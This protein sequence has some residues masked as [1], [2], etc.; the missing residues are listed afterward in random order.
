M[1]PLH[2]ERTAVRAQVNKKDI[3]QRLPT[4]QETTRHAKK[5]FLHFVPSNNEERNFSSERSD[6][7]Y[8][9]PFTDTAN[10]HSGFYKIGA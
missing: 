7:R 6:I 5:I 3:R 2:S 8:P 9:A 1:F 4:V 10:E